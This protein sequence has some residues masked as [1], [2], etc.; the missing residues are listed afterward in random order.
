MV[1]VLVQPQIHVLEIK[2][3][4]DGSKKWGLEGRDYVMKAEPSSMGLGLVPLGKRPQRTSLL[5]LPG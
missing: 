4:G 5:L 2:H 1:R 3:Q